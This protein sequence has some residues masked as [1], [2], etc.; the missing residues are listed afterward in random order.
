[1]D[2]FIHENKNY[3]FASFGMISI[4]LLRKYFNGPKSKFHRD[5]KSNIVI[6]T[7]A[8]EGIG[9][10]TA[11]QLLK[12]NATVI[13]ACRDEKKTLKVI[14]K[15]KD[16]KQR[17]RAIFMHL[18]LSNFNSVK[19]FILEFKS[20]YDRLDILVNNAATVVKNFIITRNGLETTLQVNTFSPM[21]LTQGLID[22]IHRSNGRVINVSALVHEKMTNTALYSNLHPEEY[23]YGEKNYSGIWQYGLSKLGN[24]YFTRYLHRYIE[25]NNLNI[26]TAS[27]HPGVIITELSREYK[28]ILMGL[29]RLVA[30][31]FIWLIFKTPRMGAETTLHLCYTPDEEFKSGQYYSDSR[32][33]ALLP[34]ASSDKNMESFMDYSR[35][36]I[37]SCS[38]KFDVKLEI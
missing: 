21:I 7:G 29:F 28:G 18:D 5:L 23:Y 25:K 11:F 17:S 37:D 1:M 36:L 22:I 9:K 3:F 2:K 27:L 24:V 35:Q 10:E 19:N 8:S 6:V 26:K 33:K 13:F 12:D 14:S 4:Y 16:D 38:K 30:F 20:K 34:H 15:I 32:V 31:P